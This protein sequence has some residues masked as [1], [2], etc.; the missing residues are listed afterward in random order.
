MWYKFDKQSLTY[1]RITGKLLVIGIG[2][3]LTLSLIASLITIYQAKD[4]RY[5]SAETRAIVLSQ[6]NEFTID[7][8]KDYIKQLNIRYPDVV[9]LC[10]PVVRRLFS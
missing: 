9:P 8:L 3:I 4:I 1:K 6:E 7:R 5:I 10:R 2:A